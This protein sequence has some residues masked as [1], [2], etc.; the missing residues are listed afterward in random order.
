[1]RNNEFIPFSLLN[2]E[3]CRLDNMRKVITPI[4]DKISITTVDYFYYH[5]Y[6]FRDINNK[7]KYYSANELKKLIGEYISSN[8]DK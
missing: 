2:I 1:M 5:G 6:I 4:R 3:Q 8:F 7:N